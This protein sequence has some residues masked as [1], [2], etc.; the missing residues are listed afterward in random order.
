MTEQAQSFVEQLKAAVRGQPNSL[1]GEFPAE[2]VDAM[3]PYVL[4]F[5]VRDPEGQGWH[6]L[7]SAAAQ[8][9]E[10]YDLTS[11]DMSAADQRTLGH[12]AA[13]ALSEHRSEW[14]GLLGL[15]GDVEVRSPE[16]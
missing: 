4:S 14:I 9:Q 7:E 12:L 13:L 6:E 16:G 15:D 3:V 10:K 5:F 2:Y 1:A 11:D 8:A